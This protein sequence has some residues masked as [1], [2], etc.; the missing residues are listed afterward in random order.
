MADTTFQL[1]RRSFALPVQRW[2]TRRQLEQQ[3]QN[4]ERLSDIGF[5]REAAFTEAKK[6]F[7]KT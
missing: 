5:S 1:V 2:R 3:L 4:P 6:P 7:W